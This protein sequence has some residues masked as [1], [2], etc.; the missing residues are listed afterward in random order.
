MLAVPAPETGA[1][2]DS[3]H[4]PLK[5]LM[6][7]L[8]QKDA[9]GVIL[10]PPNNSNADGRPNHHTG[11]LHAFPPCDFARQ[12]LARRAPNLSSEVVGKE[13]HLVVLVVRLTV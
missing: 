11:L 3:Q 8:R 5:N 9:A 6:A 13:E 1:A 12:Q 2:A 4:R 7:Y 10:L